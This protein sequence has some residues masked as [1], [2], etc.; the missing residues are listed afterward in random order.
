MIFRKAGFALS[1]AGEPI[2]RN[3]GFALSNAGEPIF[4]KAG[5]AFWNT[6][7][8][9]VEM[10]PTV[11]ATSCA[12]AGWAPIV[13]ANAVSERAAAPVKRRRFFILPSLAIGRFAGFRR[14]SQDAFPESRCTAGQH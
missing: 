4:R 3:A 6:S 14:L 12:A 7:N 8:W 5:F 2:L 11:T 13:V 9:P 10:S 1:N